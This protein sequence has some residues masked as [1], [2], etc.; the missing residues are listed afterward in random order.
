MHLKSDN[1][2]L[3]VCD[4]AN[5]VTEERFELLLSGYK[6]GLETSMRGREF[7][8]DSV[9]FCTKNVMK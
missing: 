8:F 2:E 5:E 9:C 6:I 3:M 7:F 4:K 1:I